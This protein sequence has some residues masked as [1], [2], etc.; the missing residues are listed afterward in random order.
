MP[1]YS[2]HGRDSGISS[3]ETAEDSITV[4]FSDGSVYLYDHHKPGE[5]HVTKMKSLADHGEGL[6]AYINT[7]V[8]TNYAKKLR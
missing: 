8:R 7:Q 5:Y 3:Y 4:T 1:H 6:N 2:N